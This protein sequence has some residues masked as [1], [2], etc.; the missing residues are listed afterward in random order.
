MLC[1]LAW[2][3]WLAFQIRRQDRR[4]SADWLAGAYALA[5]LGLL[6]RLLRAWLGRSDP[7]IMDTNWDG[8]ITSI[9]SLLVAIFGNMGYIG[10]YLSRAHERETAATVERKRQEIQSQLGAQIA[11]LD[12]QRSLSEMSAALA[13]ELGQPLTAAQV[14]GHIASAELARWPSAPSELK[15]ALASLRESIAR[16]G[17]IVTRI[18]D[19]IRQ[20]E[21][22]LTPLRWSDIYH[23]VL[24]LIPARERPAVAHLG[25]HSAGAELWIEGDRIQLSQV[26]LNLLRNALQAPLRLETLRVDIA[27]HVVGDSVVLTVSD[28]GRGMPPEVMEQIGSAFFTTKPEGLGVG[29]SISRTIVQQHGG[30]LQI[31]S[32]AG[33]GTE[34]RVVL[35]RLGV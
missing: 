34:V 14:D 21:P 27:E 17:L 25:W 6:F 33:Q 9:S 30:Q 11:H 3:S 12:R 13:H 26:L 5:A 4:K 16:A 32:Q 29:L 10:I 24:P 15:V 20:R 18:H 7:N 35:A 23:D 28:N 2:I 1:L 22:E 31:E 19:F 8:V